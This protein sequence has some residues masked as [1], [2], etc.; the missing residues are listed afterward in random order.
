MKSPAKPRRS[1]IKFEVKSCYGLVDESEVVADNLRLISS[2]E[3]HVYS[4]N[5]E[6]IARNRVVNE[7]INSIELTKNSLR[8]QRLRVHRRQTELQERQQA[9]TSQASEFAALT[10]DQ[11]ALVAN[12]SQLAEEVA[13]L[14]TSMDATLAELSDV[15]AAIKSEDPALKI[16][17]H[18]AAER[19]RRQRA[20]VDHLQTEFDALEAAARR[21][22]ASLR[23]SEHAYR[24]L[25][26]ARS[27]L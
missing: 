6:L 25:T 27:Q 7:T 20:V 3:S 1:I 8:A 13:E 21:S 5:D 16:A 24:G 23:E 4:L 22:E 11:Q 10:A 19:H 12:T 26:S 15:Y 18:D 9:I 14:Q 2:Q 17:H